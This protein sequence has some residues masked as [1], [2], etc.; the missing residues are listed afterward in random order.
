ME[1]TFYPIKLDED[2][3]G[4]CKSIGP[5]AVSHAISSDLNTHGIPADAEYVELLLG[6]TYDGPTIT[7]PD[8]WYSVNFAYGVGAPGD[9]L[10]SGLHYQATMDLNQAAGN[11]HHDV[12]LGVFR[13]PVVNG[14]F[15]V[16][17]NE[18]S[19][20]D[21]APPTGDLTWRYLGYW[22]K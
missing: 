15:N 20:S 4:Q 5:T 13:V 18:N 17:F 21:D 12:S 22:R 6:Y 11:F 7:T 10:G 2:A 8:P 19:A 16:L 14:M 3:N 1:L 9:T